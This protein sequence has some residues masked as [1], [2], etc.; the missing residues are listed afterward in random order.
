[1]TRNRQSLGRHGEAR[2]AELLLGRGFRIAERN[3]RSR[4]GEIDIVAEKGGDVYFVEVRT[5]SRAPYGPPLYS[6][7]AA[8]QARLARLASAYLA[9]R[10]SP[11]GIHFSVIAIAA[12]D[13]EI[14]W[15]EDAFVAD[16]PWG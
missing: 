8:K 15:I 16:T 11:A 14:A 1:M 5:A 6:V 7:G 12:N 9:S 2:A 3:V 10:P 4:L 13:N